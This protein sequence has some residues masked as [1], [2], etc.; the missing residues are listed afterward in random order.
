MTREDIEY[1]TPRCWRRI[2]ERTGQH[3]VH[4]TCFQPMRYRAGDNTWVCTC[5]N[6]DSGLLVAARP[7]IIDKAA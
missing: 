3:G 2:I 5:G 6:E 4:R 1:A 7:S